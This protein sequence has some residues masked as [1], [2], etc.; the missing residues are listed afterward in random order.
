MPVSTKIV[1]VLALLAAPAYGE[2]QLIFFD[3]FEDPPA[4]VGMD[5]W[6]DWVDLSW[7]GLV[8][9]CEN[10]PYYCFGPYMLDRDPD[11]HHDGAK[12]AKATRQQPYW[13]SAVREEPTLAADRDRTIRLGGYQFETFFIPAPFDPSWWECCAHDQV[14]GWITLM[15]EDETEFF[16]IGVYAHRESPTPP[17]LL[18]RWTYMSWGTTLDGWN[19]TTVHRA[20]S[21]WRRLEIVVKPYSGQVGD[22]E[23]Y[24]DGALVGQG[25]RQAGADCHGIAVTR[26]GMGANPTH[27]AEDY[28]ANS[29][30]TYWYDEISLAVEDP[31]ALPCPSPVVRFDADGDGDVDQV[32]FSIFQ[33]CFTG[34]EGSFDCSQCRCMNADG[35]T[36]IDDNDYDAFEL[37]ASG[38]GILADPACDDG[39]PLP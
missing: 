21:E 20:Q 32:D 38:P 39:L 7:S 13:Y 1:I 28:I 14:H 5:N 25:R 26:I 29:Y 22:V 24:I 27:I 37:C 9:G 23:F 30:E 6:A 15:N 12:S 36:A 8:P 3:S 33:G 11:V 16:A 34:A 18:D 17:D 4:G 31:A 19:V 2:P 35:N 10:R